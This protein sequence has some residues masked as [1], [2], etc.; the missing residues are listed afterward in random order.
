MRPYDAVLLL[1]FGGPESRDDV[2]PFLEQVLRGKNVPRERLLEVAE[3]YYH[4][5][6]VSPINGQLRELKLAVEAELA[7]RGIDLPVYWGNRNWHPF[8]SDT[9]QQ[10]GE[11]GI[12]HAL[13]WVTSAYSSYSG[14]RQYLEDIQSARD[15]VGPTAPQVD[16]VRLFWNHPRFVAA[17]VDRVK[18][19]LS[20]VSHHPGSDAELIFTA[21]SIPLAMAETCQ[22]ETQLKEV[23]RLVAEACGVDRWQLAYQSRS[24]PPHQ[25]WLEPDILDVLQSRAS[26]GDG[27]PM[28]IAPIGFLSDHMEVLFD[29]DEEARQ[30]CAELGLSYVRAATVG[31][32][33]EFIR[34]ICDLVEERLE[35]GSPRPVLGTLGPA[36]DQCRE[37]CCRYSPRPLA[38]R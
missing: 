17:W 32:H 27:S 8:L 6:G 12:R 33:P 26:A 35:P 11:D 29:L 14:C 34:M 10:M 23:C 15:H 28:V 9:L 22:Y 20:E 5:D 38:K 2:I 36:P 31:V 4:F 25:P 30:S 19:A 13:A 24:G 7:D 18:A 21:H 3:H 37:G 1:S 16:K